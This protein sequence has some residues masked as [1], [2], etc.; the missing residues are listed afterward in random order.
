MDVVIDTI[1]NAQRGTMGNQNIDVFW[2]LFI[3][4][5][6][7]QILSFEYHKHRNTKE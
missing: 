2:Y 5:Y 1:Q 6:L 4:F 3:M 7:F